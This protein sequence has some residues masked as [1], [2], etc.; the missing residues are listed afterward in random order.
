ML[1]SMSEGKTYLPEPHPYAMRTIALYRPG[2]DFPSV[3][4]TGDR[5]ELMCD[6]CQGR[7]LKGMVPVRDPASLRVLASELKVRGVAGFLLSGG[8]DPHG[9]V[10]LAPFLPEVRRIREDLGL[11]VN[12]HPGLV[13][14]EEAKE[15][16]ISADRVSFDLV[17]DQE[18]IRERMHLNSSPDDYIRS[19][20][21]LCQAAPGRVVPHILLGLGSE[22][23][24]LR[25]VREACCE[26]TSCIVLLSMIGPKVNDWEGRL[27]RA[28]KSGVE[29]DIPVILGCMRPRGRTEVEMAALEAGATGIACPGAGTVK[30]IEEKGWG[31]D[32]HNVCCAFHR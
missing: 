8:C 7:F 18:I 17:L 1:I 10:P 9:K 16:A 5:C 19:L 3:S 14:E 26:G 11:I 21:H 20:R 22:G 27:L 6:H 32:E 15:I 13:S 2:F 31:I 30:G 29:M 23:A 24:E 25:A 28:V 4:V 12:I